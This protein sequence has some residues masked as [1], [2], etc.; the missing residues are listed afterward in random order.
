MGWTDSHLHQFLVGDVRY[1]V[2]EPDWNDGT[3]LESGI[4]VGE[5]LK[6]SKDWI[7]YEYDFGDSWEHRV[8]LEKINP[9]TVEAITP[10]CAGGR[11]SCPPEDV[12]G[13]WGYSDFLDAYK[14]R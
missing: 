5:L 13:V 10:I 11:K 12:G 7:V 6:K 2:P 1:G 14:E 3:I 8:E 9:F 4:R